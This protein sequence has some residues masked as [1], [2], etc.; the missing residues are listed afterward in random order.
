MNP[1]ILVPA[2]ASSPAVKMH[3]RSAEKSMNNATI[4]DESQIIGQ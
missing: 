3:I 4:N 2:A 1:Q